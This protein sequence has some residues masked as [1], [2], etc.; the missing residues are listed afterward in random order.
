M[1]HVLKCLTNLNCFV[2]CHWEFKISPVFCNFLI[3]AVPGTDAHC[4]SRRWGLDLFSDRRAS[5]LVWQLWWFHTL[6]SLQQW[7]SLCYTLL[8][9]WFRCLL[10]FPSKDIF[11]YPWNSLWTVA[12]QSHATLV[13]DVIM[14]RFRKDK[15]TVT[16][17]QTFKVSVLRFHEAYCTDDF[18][19]AHLFRRL[20]G[21]CTIQ[22]RYRTRVSSRRLTHTEIHTLT[23]HFAKLILRGTL[24]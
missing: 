17:E 21:K 11:F 8:Y 23:Q 18:Q 24:Q 3:G 20:V 13:N 12:I 22:F 4:Q 2:T 14:R 7:S 1:F 6:W 15:C 5:C 19:K 16:K 10:Q 9:P